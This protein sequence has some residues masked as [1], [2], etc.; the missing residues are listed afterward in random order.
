MIWHPSK[1]NFYIG[2]LDTS[3]NAEDLLGLFGLNTTQTILLS[4]NTFQ[5]QW[6]IDG[7]WHTNNRQKIYDKISQM[8]WSIKENY[9]FKE[10][11]NE[12]NTQDNKCWSKSHTLTYDPRHTQNDR[13]NETIYHPSELNHWNSRI[14]GPSKLTPLGKRRHLL[15]SGRLSEFG[16]YSGGRRG[17]KKSKVETTMSE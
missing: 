17:S 16:R 9:L 14:S 2:N 5:E 8:V 11:S 6:A 4:M 15:A 3:T 1:Q 10:Q 13:G 7:L 12:N